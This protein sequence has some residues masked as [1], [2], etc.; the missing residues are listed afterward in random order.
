MFENDRKRNR[1]GCKFIVEL[2]SLFFVLFSTVPAFA[3]VEGFPIFIAGPATINGQEVSDGDIV[4]LEVDGVELAIYEVVSN[5]NL[6]SKWN[7]VLTVRTWDN[8]GDPSETPPFPVGEAGDEAL[9][10][11]NGFPVD[12]NPVILGAPKSQTLLAINVTK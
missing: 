9:I 12:E 2:V 5:R 1:L 10:Y 3:G 6:P 8:Q 4:S 7:Y 11:I